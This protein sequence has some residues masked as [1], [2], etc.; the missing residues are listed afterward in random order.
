MKC[1]TVKEQRKSSVQRV[2]ERRWD[3]DEETTKGMEGEV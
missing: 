3:L 1:V 2:D